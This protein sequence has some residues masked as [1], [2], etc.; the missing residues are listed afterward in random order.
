MIGVGYD[1]WSTITWET[2]EYPMFFKAKYSKNPL[3]PAEFVSMP[4]CKI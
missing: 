1:Q 2:S 3:Y 4:D